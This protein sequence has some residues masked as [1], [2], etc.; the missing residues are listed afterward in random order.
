MRFFHSNFSFYP[1]KLHNNLQLISFL[2]VYI[3]LD[4]LITKFYKIDRL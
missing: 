3:P 1:N 4:K 2:I